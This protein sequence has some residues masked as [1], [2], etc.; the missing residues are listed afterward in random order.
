[1]GKVH[2]MYIDNVLQ[3]DDISF[4]LHNMIHMYMYIPPTYDMFIDRLG[5]GKLT[6]LLAIPIYRAH[7]WD[8]TCVDISRSVPPIYVKHTALEARSTY[9]VCISSHVTIH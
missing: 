6:S 5:G 1:M 9:V 8:I 3:R 4:F 7:I 2:V